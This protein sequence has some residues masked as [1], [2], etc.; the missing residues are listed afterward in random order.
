VSLTQL[1]DLCLSCLYILRLSGI[2]PCRQIVGSYVTALDTRG[3]S[4]T[5]AG[6][7]AEEINFWDA[8]VQTAALHW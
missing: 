4:L 6:L 7:D 5:L 8:R 2:A 1:Q 3:F